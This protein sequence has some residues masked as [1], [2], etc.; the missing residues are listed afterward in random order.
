MNLQVGMPGELCPANMA[1]LVQKA[2]RH[3]AAARLAM[4]ILGNPT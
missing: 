3:T 1:T 2:Q 4:D